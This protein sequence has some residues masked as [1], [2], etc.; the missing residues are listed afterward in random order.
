MRRLAD[1]LLF[2]CI[3]SVP[4]VAQVTTSPTPGEMYMPV[5]EFVSPLQGFC[6]PNILT[7]GTGGW[8][9]VVNPS[10]PNI[11]AGV[12]VSLYA[13][14]SDLNAYATKDDLNAVATTQDANAKN[15]A[16]VQSRLF[17]LVAISAAL[18]D[19]VPNS[20][21]RFALRFNAAGFRGNLAGAVSFSTNITR[22][23][24]FS[25]NY[26]RAKSENAFSGGLNISFH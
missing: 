25:M 20:G 18:T 5:L 15:A 19:A 4:A 1:V 26:G 2:I 8:C 22:A 21:D 14:K 10:N 23:T 13:T 24:R 11:P 3:L 16:K 17:S 9:N 12:P 7:V 6:F